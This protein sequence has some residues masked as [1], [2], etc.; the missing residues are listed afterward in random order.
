MRYLMCFLLLTGVSFAGTYAPTE[1]SVEL[2][3]GYQK[4]YIADVDQRT[5]LY[6]FGTEI[7][8]VVPVADNVSFI[9]GLDAQF[10][11]AADVEADP[12]NADYYSIDALMRI[13]N[14]TFGLNHRGNGGDLTY[15]PHDEDGNID[16]EESLYVG[17]SIE[18]LAL[19]YHTKYAVA[20]LNIPFKYSE[21]YCDEHDITRYM[22]VKVAGKFDLTDR[23]GVYGDV[24][25][26]TKDIG[27]NISVSGGVRFGILS[28][29]DI[30]AGYSKGYSD[31]MGL[32]FRKQ[33]AAT[34]Q[35]VAKIN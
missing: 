9:V 4:D 6:K 13:N 1:S 29:L 16:T 19:N 26:G 28:N 12:V 11:M 35:L 18:S 31:Q 7:K 14:V 21:Y 24:R 8:Y 22:G 23:F 10:G 3:G 32:F 33:E 15:I 30:R 27:D 25:T 34:I 20:K 17:R 2:S 5:N